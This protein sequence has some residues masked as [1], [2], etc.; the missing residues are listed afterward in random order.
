MLSAAGGGA[1]AVVRRRRRRP[2]AAPRAAKRSACGR[3]RQQRRRREAG[4]GSWAVMIRNAVSCKTTSTGPTPS[5]YWRRSPDRR[6]RAV[7]RL[8]RRRNRYRPFSGRRAP[9]ARSTARTTTSWN[10]LI[11]FDQ[12]DEYESF[13]ERMMLTD[14]DYSPVKGAPRDLAAGTSSAS[15]RGLGTHAASGAAAASRPQL[16]RP[17]P[18]PL[19]AALYPHLAPACCPVGKKS[20]YVPDENLP[21]QE[22]I[23]ALRVGELHAEH[24]VDERE[25]LRLALDLRRRHRRLDAVAYLTT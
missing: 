12:T 9:S 2:A 20:P 14:E 22:S 11:K 17:L 15:E 8:A 10:Y 3:R 6:P 7:V 13:T 5:R 23:D 16:S 25:Q 19:R 18:L 4:E 24:L 21:S 1:T